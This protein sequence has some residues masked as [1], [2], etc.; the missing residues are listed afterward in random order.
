[1]FLL[2]IAKSLALLSISLLT[3]AVIIFKWK[4]RQRKPAKVR[5]YVHPKFNKVL[6]IFS[7]NLMRGWERDGAALCVYHKGECVVDVWGGLS[8]RDSQREWSKETMQI[9]FSSSKALGAVCVALLVDKGHLKYSDRISSFWPEFGKLGKKEITVEMVMTHTAGLA[10]I[11]KEITWEDARDP[12]K[13]AQILENQSPRWIP[14]S[15]IGYHAVSYGWLVDQ[16]IRRSDPLSR[17]SGQFWKEEIADKHGLDIHIGL[18]L[19]LAWRVARITRPSLWNRVD[20]FITDPGNVD[21]PFLFKQFLTDGLS[22]K[23][24]SNPPWMQTIFSVTVNNPEM[25]QLEQLAA[26]GIGT[27]RDLAHFG[28]LLIEG[29]VI[30]N[31]TLQL[32]SETVFHDRDIVSGARA[33]R[34][35]GTT[36]VDYNSRDTKFSFSGHAGLGGQNIRWDMKNDL[37]VGYLS[38]GLKGGLGDRARSYVKVM[39][40]LLD[41]ITQEEIHKTDY[42]GST[43]ENNLRFRGTSADVTVP[44][45]SQQLMSHLQRSTL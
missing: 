27:A 29:K 45:T 21:Y 35:R 20:E 13:M 12:H 30:K 2:I 4:E 43:S 41:C 16:I 3:I 38:N 34:G 6:E 15:R 7:D 31:E 39:E 5:G 18:P 36:I 22:V 26:L 40:T 14:G 33:K 42:D 11:D 19:E 24:A 8:D 17:G 1:M 9:I 44:S 28:K 10:M 32:I 25:Y 23:V 37:V